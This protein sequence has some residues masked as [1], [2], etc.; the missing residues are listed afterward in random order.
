MST[1]AVFGFGYMQ[2]RVQSR[3]AQLASNLLWSQLD[4]IDEFSAY[5]EE[6]R[7]TSLSPLISGISAQS[8]S[9]D[10]DLAFRHVFLHQVIE[11]STWMPQVWHSAID[12][13]QWLPDIPLLSYLLNEQS[14]LNWMYHDKY[15]S[16][17]LENQ[18]LSVAEAMTETGGGCLLAQGTSSAS[19]L[20]M[21]LQQWPILWPAGSQQFARGIDVLIELLQENQI[22]FEALSSQEA[23][24][25]RDELQITLRIFFRRHLLQPATA[26]AYLALMS[27]QLERLRAELLQRLLFSEQRLML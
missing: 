8:N 17:M 3:Y 12:W 18:E 10:I 23:W 21:W 16:L 7:V 19:M 22:H 26:F 25:S 11:L 14:P 15:L 5:L 13:L 27:L 9:H 4:A 6:S 1:K 20:S 24:K 2:A